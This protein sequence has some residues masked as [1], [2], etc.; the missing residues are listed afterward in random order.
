MQRRPSLDSLWLSGTLDRK[1]T[2]FEAPNTKKNAPPPTPPADDGNLRKVFQKLDTE[3]VTDNADPSGSQ[4][5]ATDVAEE[6][7]QR[8]AVE[9]DVLGAAE[10]SVAALLR[11]EV[12]DSW[13]SGRMP[14]IASKPTRGLQNS[15]ASNN[16]KCTAAKPKPVAGLK[17][18]EGEDVSGSVS[19]PFHNVGLCA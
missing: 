13:T 16:S 15:G 14:V 8:D 5:T 18:D 3:I 7:M 6:G 9:E 10:G 19:S 17:E 12:K 4:E 2:V 11:R 1:K